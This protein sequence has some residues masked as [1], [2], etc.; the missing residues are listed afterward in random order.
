MM[1]T[2]SLSASRKP[3][4]SRLWQCIAIA[5]L[6]LFLTAFL[7]GCG[8]GKDRQRY[9]AA[10]NGKT[11][12]L[13]RGDPFPLRMLVNIQVGAK[14]QIVELDRSILDLKGEPKI[15]G[16]IVVGGLARI[17]SYEYM[18]QPVTKGTTTLKMNLVKPGV[19]EPLDTFSVTIVVE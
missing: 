9:D 3:T 2:S 12:T 8:G 7:Q 14:W 5:L 15:S 18:F 13:H 11:L 16:N 10:L 19:E 6:G 17:Y 4:V 1:S